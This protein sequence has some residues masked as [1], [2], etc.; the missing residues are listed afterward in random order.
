V[1]VGP[2]DFS[3]SAQLA[4]D[5]YNATRAWID[6]GTPDLAATIGIHQHD[7]PVPAHAAN[8]DALHRLRARPDPPPDGACR[9]A[10][11][12]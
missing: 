6:E 2:A 7:R 10:V 3:R 4:G 5:A 9:T 12:R 11:R 8:F 1:A